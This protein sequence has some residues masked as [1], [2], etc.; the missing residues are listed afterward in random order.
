M[1]NIVQLVLLVLSALGASLAATFTYFAATATKKASRGAA[2]LSCLQNYIGIMKD[3]RKA[4]EEGTSRLAE[5]FYRELLDLH[6]SEFHLWRDGVIPDSVML[7]WIRVRKRNFNEDR[8]TCTNE[9][10]K[11]VTYKDCWSKLEGMN[12]FE[13]DD[14]FVQ[15]MNKVHAGDITTLK[16]LKKLK[17]QFKKESAK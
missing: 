10:G 16:A 8:I 5:E 1:V 11:I 9:G 12:Y 15:F 2:L 7:P 13:I 17:R 6:W 3:K 4:E 14:P